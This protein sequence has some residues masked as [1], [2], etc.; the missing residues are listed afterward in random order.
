MGVGSGVA[1]GVGSG[2]AVGVGSGV[3]VGV[4][5]GVIAV[6]TGEGAC[7]RGGLAH[8]ASSAAASIKAPSERRIAPP[9]RQPPTDV[10]DRSARAVEGIA[11]VS[12]R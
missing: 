2:V 8:P 12:R 5:A 10:A 9:R 1:V 7:V 4:G 11:P 6:A 3:A